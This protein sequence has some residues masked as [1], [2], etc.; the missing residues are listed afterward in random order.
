MEFLELAMGA[1]AVVSLWLF[2]REVA[3]WMRV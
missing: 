3:R 1:T 2:G